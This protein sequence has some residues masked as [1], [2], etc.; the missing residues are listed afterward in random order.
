[1]NPATFPHHLV[2]T[3][4]LLG[5]HPTPSS[6]HWECSPFPQQGMWSGQVIHIA[7]H[8]ISLSRYWN[9]QLLWHHEGSYPE[10]QTDGQGAA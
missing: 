8:G 10:D 3:L 4:I 1:M 2:T 6:P 7:L 9:L 5:I